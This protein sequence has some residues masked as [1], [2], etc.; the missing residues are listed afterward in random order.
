MY[1][2]ER[3]ASISSDIGTNDIGWFAARQPAVVRFLEDRLG[4][5]ERHP[6]WDLLAVGLDAAH[7]LTGMFERQHGV[8]PARISAGLLER[9]EEAA[10]GEIQRGEPAHALH[11]PALAEWVAALLADPPRPLD[12]DETH[13]LG[14]ALVTVVYA[15]DAL[16]SGRSMP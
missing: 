1:V 6:T 8:P 14:V 11:Q 5:A 2:S 16:T 12:P 9:A 10:L 15:L 4:G 7:A 3:V 13:V